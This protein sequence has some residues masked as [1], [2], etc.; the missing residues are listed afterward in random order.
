M[1][2]FHMSRRTQRRWDWVS[3]RISWA[4]APRDR[5]GA[6]RARIR[7]RTDYDRPDCRVPGAAE[8]WRGDRVGQSR[9][10][11]RPELDRIRLVGICETLEHRA[12]N[13]TR[14][15]H[16]AVLRLTAV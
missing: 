6:P 4:A 13:I 11:A 8:A 3:L 15:D 2:H 7:A 9:D 10:G 1:L 12:V 5:S 14:T 16:G